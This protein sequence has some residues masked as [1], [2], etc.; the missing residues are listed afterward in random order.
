MEVTI[1]IRAGNPHRSR[2][3]NK[4]GHYNYLLGYNAKRLSGIPKPVSA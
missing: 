2:Q 3:F 4:T 1:T